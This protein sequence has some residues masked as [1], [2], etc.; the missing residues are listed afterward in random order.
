MGSMIKLK[1]LSCGK[2]IGVPGE[3]SAGRVKCPQCGAVNS[4][5]SN[6]AGAAGNVPT[7]PTSTAPMSTAQKSS[8]TMSATSPSPNPTQN[9]P[10]AFFVDSKAPLAQPKQQ[11]RKSATWPYLALAGGSVAVLAVVALLFLSSAGSA[12]ADDALALEPIL[13]ITIQESLPMNVQAKLT[14]AD[15]WK[16]KVKFSLVAGPPGAVID[17]HAGLVR[18]QPTEEQGPGQFQVTVRVADAAGVSVNHEQTF[19]ITVL[20]DNR[21]PTLEPIADVIVGAGQPMSLQAKGSDADFPPVKLQYSLAAGAP[22]GARIDATTGAI[23]W[24]PADADAG[25]TFQFIVLA[26][27]PGPRGMSAQQRFAVQ[28]KASERPLDRF[29]AGLQARG[30]KVQ[31]MGDEHPPQLSRTC[32][33][34]EVDGQTVRAFEFST[35]AEAQDAATQTAPDASV[36]FGKPM[37]WKVQPFLFHSDRLI[38]LYAGDDAN[39]LGQLDA[40]FGRP[41]AVGRPKE[42]ESVASAAPLPEINLPQ[43]PQPGVLED[44]GDQVLLDLYEKKK[45]FLP[46]EYPT[47][48]RIYAERFERQNEQKIKQAFGADYEE[49]NKWL[50]GHRDIKEELYTAIKTEY[51]D[52]TA[53]L[54]IFRDLK[55]KFPTKIESYANLAIATAVTWDQPRS[56]VYDYG[57]HQRRTKSTM[58]EGELDAAG[59]FQF[60]LDTEKFMQ[61]RGQ[62][63]PW[64]FLVLIVDHRTSLTER[65]WALGNYLPQRAMFGKCYADVPYDFEMLRTG[66]QQCKL[67]GQVYS[68]P[69]IRQL[70]GVCAMQADYAARVGKSM[71]VPAA[72]VRGESNSG[73][74]HAWVMWVELLRVTPGSIGFS[75]ESHGRYRGDQY[76]VGRLRDPQTG[77]EITDREL[78]LRLHTV[79]IGA[80]AKRQADLI[81]QSYLMLSL[82][83]QMDIGERLR[84]LDQAISLSPGNEDAWMTMAKM[85]G[86]E[87]VKAKHGKQMMTALDKL[88]RTFGNFPDFTWKIFDDLIAFQGDHKQRTKLY[89]RLVVLYEQAARPDLACEARLKLSDYHVTEG[90][91]LDAVQGLAF[92]I[93]KFPDE[94]RYVPRMLDKLEQICQGLEGADKELLAFY[95]SFLPMIPQMRGNDPSKYCMAMF[96]RGIDRFKQ[97]NQPQLAQAYEAQLAKIRAGQGRKS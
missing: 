25:Q 50:A 3:H 78:E 59:N 92:T 93:K 1:C 18:W 28:V 68:L 84:F 35:A 10:P 52:V 54:A 34:L 5:P 37:K 53:V 85:S 96:E 87:E 69:N 31:V 43:L 89:E 17:E 47:L 45:L 66:S 60:L 67:G 19:Q 73:E 24:T 55:Q 65:Q 97:Y 2:T 33:V 38:A 16:D 63:L 9:T 41:F 79:G 49:M 75:L 12:P 56:G 7:A 15:R 32:S 71:G 46:I 90:R 20:E 27:E 74:L 23:T 77:Q 86:E 21:P 83:K 94:G 51:D 81:M 36:V 61:G 82:K 26:S 11:R 39:V 29:V 8:A 70:G 14:N 57:M 58:P 88:F 6:V 13:D 62:F 95:A 22:S 80:A 40:Q 72:Y 30:V 64:E 4:V 48:R 44:Q 76:Y 91:P 42:T